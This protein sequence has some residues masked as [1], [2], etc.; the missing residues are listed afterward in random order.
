MIKNNFHILIIILAILLVN[1]WPSFFTIPWTYFLLDTGFSPFTEFRFFFEVSFYYFFMDFGSYALW[2]ALWSKVYFLLVI[3]SGIYAGILL[4]RYVWTLYPEY[5]SKYLDIVS[6]IA[7]IYNPFIYERIISQTGIALWTYCIIIASLF[8]LIEKQTISKWYKHL[9]WASMFFSIS[10]MIFPH[11]ILLVALILLGFSCTYFKQIWKYLLIMLWIILLN[12]N[13]LIGD[14]YLQTNQ[15]V[16]KLET[17]DRANIEVFQ[18]NSLSG[19]GVDIT[20]L[21]G[22]GFWWERYHIVSPDDIISFWYV[23]GFL[24]LWVIIYGWYKLFLRE[25]RVFFIL[26]SIA[27]LSYI[28]SMWIAS[29]LWSWISELLYAHIPFYIGMR[30]PGKWLGVTQMVYMIY[31]TVW[32]A[33][34]THI[35]TTKHEAKYIAWC[36]LALLPILWTPASLVWYWGQLNIS[37]Y[38]EDIFITQEFIQSEIDVAD[39]M[40]N[41]PWHSYMAC[42]WTYGKITS[43]RNK[44]IFYPQSIVTSDNIEIGH[45]YTNSTSTLS[46]DIDAY[47]KNRELSLL[48]RNDIKYILFSATCADRQNYEFLD[49]ETETFEKVFESEHVDIYK[50]LYEKK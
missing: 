46:A 9:I 38:P 39:T 41:L 30:E 33:S 25:K 10:W 27:L 3:G 49:E 19:L 11:A 12:L 5:K 14:F 20:H 26:T 18:G 8:L 50:I 1:L 17:F 28:L 40:L 37:D 48:E 16:S 13:W 29:T 6:I 23:F 34:L 43:N 22:Y 4:S 44:D 32:A 35:T 21:L 42:D 36:I 15:Q 47:L 2:Y 24:A 45:L 31:F 7:L